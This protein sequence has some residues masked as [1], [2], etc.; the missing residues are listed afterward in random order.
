MKVIVHRFNPENKT[1]TYP[2][3]GLYYST[4]PV[5]DDVQIWEG[6][7]EEIFKRFD[8]ANNRLRY[9]N[10]SFYKFALNEINDRYIAWYKSLSEA[11]KFEMF[12]GNGVVD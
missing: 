12:Y 8:K 11:T 4:K 6:T 1:R 10:G 7:E 5:R 9:C 3:G 2:S